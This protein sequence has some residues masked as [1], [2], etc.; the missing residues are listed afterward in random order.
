MRK[1][2]YLLTL[3]TVSAAAQIE[4]NG[5]DPSDVSRDLN[6]LTGS[7]GFGNECGVSNYMVSNVYE[8]I[9]FNGNSINVRFMSLDVYGSLTNYGEGLSLLD[10]LQQGLFS[11]ECESST[12]ILHETT[13]SNPVE[14]VSEIKMFPNPASDKVNIFGNNIESIVVR[15][16][17]GRVLLKV[18]SPKRLNV[19]TIS[20]LSSGLYFVSINNTVKKL[21]KK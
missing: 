18:D 15:D 14:E 11:M 4:Y 10:A 21:I 13:L 5:F 20:E 7:I 2:L 1:L 12:I 9:E 19:L 16:L 6:N 17:T 8:G 3:I